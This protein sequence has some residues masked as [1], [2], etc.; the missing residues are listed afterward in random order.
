MGRERHAQL[1]LP[2]LAVWHFRRDDVAEAGKGGAPAWGARRAPQARDA[3]RRLPES[4]TVALGGLNGE[5]NVSLGGEAVED[6]R[7][8]ERSRQPEPGAAGGRQLGD[9][10]PVE[11]DPARIRP[12]LAGQLSDQRGL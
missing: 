12:E 9:V 10:A 5:R 1:E 4:E 11:D 7:D 6:A 3:F 2:G 8:L